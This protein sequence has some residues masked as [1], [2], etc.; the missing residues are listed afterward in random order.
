MA[1]FSPFLKFF[2][3]MSDKNNR[4]K[5]TG[6]IMNNFIFILSFLF[7][8]TSCGEEVLTTSDQTE[9]FSANDVAIFQNNT[10]AQMQLQKPPV[11]I[12]YIV[13]NSGSTL[14]N[15]FQSIKSQIKKTLATISHEFDYHVYI[16]PL[17]S[18]G[19][20]SISS[21][22]LIVSDTNSLPTGSLNITTPEN[23]NM[24]AQAS[25][26]N[27]EKGFE[28]AYNL[29][30]HNRSNGIFR[31]NAN[32]VVV[33]ISNGDDTDTTY[34][35]GGNKLINSSAF[36]SHKSK[37]L[38]VLSPSSGL[39][40]NA[41]SFRFMSLTA[42]SMCESGWNIGSAYQQMSR[43]I[44]DQ[45]GFTDNSLKDALDLCSKNYTSLFSSINN[46]IRQ[47][48]VGHKYDHWKISNASSSSIEESDIKVYKIDA[49]NNKVEIPRSTSN[50]FEYLGYRTNLN[51]RYSP[52]SG[53]PATGLMIKLNGNARVEFPECV[54]ATTRTPTEYYGYITIPREPIQSSIKIEIDGVSIGQSNRDGWSYIGWRESINIK[55]PGPTGASTSPAINK[56]GYTIQLFGN[57]IFSNGST[58]N[59]YYKPKSL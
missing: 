12:L 51:T 56:S 8:L 3:K 44:Y 48:V 58:I 45:Q 18:I 47:V 38:E 2:K 52:T 6:K 53:E 40:M 31:N 50:G 1:S 5:L 23:L 13:D 49:N 33:M 29:I 15:S 4:E 9:V 39:A 14:A 24:F 30:R 17:N 46:S 36:A 22:P 7:I 21:Y 28:R 37:L 42:K 34:S 57:A 25:G 16:A 20:E 54:I 11:D 41:E 55:V 10:C 43:E 35:F 19:S 59:V 26:G 27:T 32:T